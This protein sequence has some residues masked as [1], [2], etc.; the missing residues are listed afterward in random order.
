MYSSKKCFVLK[1]LGLLISVI[2]PFI[3]TISYFPIWRERGAETVLSGL[4]LL[5]LLISAIPLFKAIKNALRSPSAP[6]VWFF[7]FIT[8][9]ALSKIAEDVTV[10]AFTGFISNLVGA[11]LFRLSRKGSEE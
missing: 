1:L 7:V 10:I 6:L 3:A 5:L 9:F 11:F 4:S 2:P 8:F